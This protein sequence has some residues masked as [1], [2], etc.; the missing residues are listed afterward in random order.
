MKDMSGWRYLNGFIMLLAWLLCSCTKNEEE[1]YSWQPAVMNDGLKVST[2]V[3]Q[4]MDPVAI[5]STY[6]EAK[7]LDNLY[8]FLILKNGY[9]IAEEYFNGMT[10]NDAS[11]TASVTK[12]IISALAGIAIREKFITGTDQKLKDFFP[13]IDWESTDPRKSEI[14]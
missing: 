4:G 1:G 9:L 5:D 12:S 11:S 13:E 10:V 7:N 8:S 6:E 2:A 3:E 14:C